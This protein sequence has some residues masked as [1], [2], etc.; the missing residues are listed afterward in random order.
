MWPRPLTTIT[1]ED[2]EQL[3]RN[4]TSESRHLEF[5][6]QPPNTSETQVTRF[7]LTVAAFANA[8]G[9]Y[10]I[11]GIDAES[12]ESGQGGSASRIL[13]IEE[14][15]DALILRLE[16]CLLSRIHPRVYP[17]LRRVSVRPVQS[18]DGDDSQGKGDGSGFGG[19]GDQPD[20]DVLAIRIPASS[21][22]PHAVQTNEGFKFP[23]RVSGGK[24][25]MDMH[26]IRQA[27]FNSENASAQIERFVHARYEQ[28]LPSFRRG[29]MLLHLLPLTTDNRVDVT[30]LLGENKMR[31]FYPIRYNTGGTGSHYN[32]EG[33]VVDAEEGVTQLF[34]DGRIEAIAHR[35]TTDHSD[36]NTYLF[37]PSVVCEVRLAVH[38]Y[39]ELLTSVMQPF[40]MVVS[41][42]LNLPAK[43][44][45]HVPNFIR[46][47]RQLGRE[48]LLLPH[49]LVEEPPDDWAIPLRT[50]FDVLWNSFGFARC[51]YYDQDGNWKEPSG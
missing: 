46:D 28:H 51:P 5:K 4:R 17:G 33:F 7:A 38:R 6:R 31:G 44:C 8:G 2:I 41:L 37:A 48:D 19:G 49:I 23:V 10:L 1:G 34:R 42:A 24:Q 32:L 26:E 14:N 18:S 3:V 15:M 16:G 9:G 29:S 21:Q 47:P 36:G 11:Y 22:T 43:T 13:G 35:W 27:I 30:N 12:D 40:P 20:V 25:M 50:I 39:V 45:I